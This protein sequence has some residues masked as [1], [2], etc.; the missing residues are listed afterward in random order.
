MAFLLGWA[1]S[2][3]MTGEEG[4]E[5]LETLWMGALWGSMGCTVPWAPTRTTAPTQRSLS[6]AQVLQTQ[7]GGP[8]SSKETSGVS[9]L[10]EGDRARAGGHIKPLRTQSPH[11]GSPALPPLQ[12]GPGQRGV[13]P[14]GLGLSIPCLVSSLDF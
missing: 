14:G 3:G 7:P 4:S 8:C 13:V 1:G 2:F 9:G 5:V 12:H 11:R 10:R 6:R